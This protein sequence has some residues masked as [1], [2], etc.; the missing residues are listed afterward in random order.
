[1][2]KQAAERETERDEFCKKIETLESKLRDV[3]KERL[4][5]DN[6]AKEV[7][8]VSIKVLLDCCETYR[9]VENVDFKWRKRPKSKKNHILMHIFWPFT[10]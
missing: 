5:Y 2:E 9:Q 6:I 10:L 8:L 4:K 7:C 1:M 3:D